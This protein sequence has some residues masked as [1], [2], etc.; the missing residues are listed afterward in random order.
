M[1]KQP[2]R[3]IKVKGQVYRLA[4]RPHR[5]WE[6]EYEDPEPPPDGVKTHRGPRDPEDEDERQMWKHLDR[7]QELAN[8]PHWDAMQ[9]LLGPLIRQSFDRVLKRMNSGEVTEDIQQQLANLLNNLDVRFSM[10][11]PDMEEKLGIGKFLKEIEDLVHDPNLFKF[12]DV[13]GLSPAGP[14]NMRDL[15]KEVRHP[16]H[17]KNLGFTLGIGDDTYWNVKRQG[18]PL[19]IKVNGRVYRRADG[20]PEAKA[21]D[22]QEMS[23][24]AVLGAD[25]GIAPAKMEKHKGTLDDYK[26]SEGKSFYDFLKGTIKPD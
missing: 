7:E 18:A 15:V 20:G 22:P 3:A 12:H 9:T 24:E 4:K 8:D 5:N 21:T 11:N 13:E 6:Q 25:L 1:S 17:L 16:G 2:P 14:I 26:N 10:L 19:E 23:D